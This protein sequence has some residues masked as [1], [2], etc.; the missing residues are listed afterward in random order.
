[1][2]ATKPPT[3]TWA[4][5]PRVNQRHIEFDGLVGREYKLRYDRKRRLHQRAEKIREQHKQKDQ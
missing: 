4:G 1:M 5:E 2:I 3:L